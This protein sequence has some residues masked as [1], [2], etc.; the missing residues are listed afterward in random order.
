MNIYSPNIPDEKVID[1]NVS[2]WA[3]ITS[4]IITGIITG[5]V[6]GLAIYF[7]QNMFEIKRNLKSLE[8]DF[9]IFEVKLKNKLSLYNSDTLSD[10][11]ERNIPNNFLEAVILM[12]DYPIDFWV[13]EMQKSKQYSKISKV[14]KALHTYSDF[15][16]VSSELNHKLPNRFLE[17]YDEVNYPYLMAPMFGV[18]NDYDYESLKKF[19]GIFLNDGRI[20]YL[21]S[22]QDEE[23][24]KDIIANYKLIRKD[25]ITAMENLS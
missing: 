19:V 20:D 3:A 16:K 15:V 23:H 25:F 2:F 17:D 18:I 24:F 7:I 1:F 6:V 8:K 14:H 13:D 5:L 4:G 10:I 9:S 21:K 11:G 12:Q 22:I